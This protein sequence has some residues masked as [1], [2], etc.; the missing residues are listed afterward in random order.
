MKFQKLILL[1]LTIIL[2]SCGTSERVITEDGNVYEIRGNKYF[3]NGNNVTELLSEDEKKNITASLNKRIEAERLALEKQEELVAEQKRIEKALKEAEAKQKEAEAKQKA[4]EKKQEQLEDALKA[5]E[6]A[7]QDFLKAKERLQ[8]KKEKYQKL[9]DAG[10]LSPLDEEKWKGRFVD[11][12]KDLK[13]ANQKLE[14]L[15]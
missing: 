10:K 11:L 5:K 14:N 4:V 2:L 12:E 1:M 8:N 6:D 9:K 15:K 7:R 13:E 3:N